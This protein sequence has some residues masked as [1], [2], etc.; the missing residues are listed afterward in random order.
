M[1]LSSLSQTKDLREGVRRSLLRPVITRCKNPWKILEG[2]PRQECALLRQDHFT[3]EI[4]ISCYSLVPRIF[5]AEDCQ[6]QKII[7]SGNCDTVPDQHYQHLQR[8][9]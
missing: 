4:T 2:L 7:H 6:V 5:P 1:V 8:A 3:K 9:Y